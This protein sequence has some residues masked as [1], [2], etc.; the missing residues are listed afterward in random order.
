MAR[1]RSRESRFCIVAIV[2]YNVNAVVPKPAI[3]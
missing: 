2:R 3:T 1:Q